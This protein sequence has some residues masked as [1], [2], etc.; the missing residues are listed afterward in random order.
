M[1]SAGVY[2]LRIGGM[3]RDAV[4]PHAGLWNSFAFRPSC[5]AR[6]AEIDSA[7]GTDDKMF[8]IRLVNHYRE[9]VGIIR[10]ARVNRLPM[11]A[12]IDGLPGKMRSTGVDH[13]RIAGVYRERNDC[14][15]FRMVDG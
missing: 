2:D 11:L 1:S 12:A 4:R 6:I 5:A 3:L 14:F 15:N 7:A 8:G 13:L 10:K 9:N